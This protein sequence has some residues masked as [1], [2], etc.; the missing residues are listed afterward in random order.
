MSQHPRKS[1]LDC[2]EKHLGAAW[3][4]IGEHGDGYPHRMLAIGHL[5]E[6]GEESWA[7]PELHAAIR[8]MRK[9][10]HETGECPKFEVLT[11]LIQKIK[12]I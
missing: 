8:D 6:A 11:L 7:W 3:V 1:C 4:L 10:Y 5:H 2:V 9:I 12:G